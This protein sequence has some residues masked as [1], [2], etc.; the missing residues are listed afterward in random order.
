M[1]QDPIAGH[2]PAR[3]QSTGGGARP[4]REIRPPHHDIAANERRTVREPRGRLIEQD[5]QIGRR[6]QR[7]ASRIET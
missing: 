6:D 4:R 5:R 7:T 2:D 1:D 3:P